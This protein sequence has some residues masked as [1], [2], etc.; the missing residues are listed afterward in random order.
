M[1]DRA[2]VARVARVAPKS[3]YTLTRAREADNG[4]LLPLRA[5][6][7][8]NFIFSMQ[9]SGTSWPFGAPF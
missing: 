1:I 5:T 2:L 3:Y 9:L 8:K 4:V 6:N 7:Q